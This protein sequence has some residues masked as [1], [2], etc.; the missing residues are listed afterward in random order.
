MQSIIAIWKERDVLLGSAAETLDPTTE[1]VIRT[2]LLDLAVACIELRLGLAPPA[3]AAAARQ[4][5]LFLIDQANEACGP[6][7]RLDRLRRAA[8][9]KPA[10]A[11]S[12]DE[13]ASENFRAVD[14]YDLGRSYLRV[15]RFQEAGVEFQRVLDERPQDFWPNFYQGI[16]AYRLG[17]FHDSLAAFRTCIALAPGSAECYYNRA[18]AAEAMGRIED[19]VRDYGRALELDPA[20]WSAS[21]NRGILAYK[22]GRNDGAITDFRKALR[23]APDERSSGLIHYNLALAQAAEGDRERALASAREAVNLGHAAARDLADRLGRDR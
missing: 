11:D 7:A 4:D 10:D 8:A 3:E 14:H 5:A 6:S 18:L 16:C 20:L 22:N 9:G 21:L 12:L 19:S 15:G 23:S 13:E 2:D 1:R 17:R